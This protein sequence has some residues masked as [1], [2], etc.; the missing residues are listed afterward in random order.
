MHGSD[1]ILMSDDTTGDK[2]TGINNDLNNTTN[3]QNNLGNSSDNVHISE[4]NPNSLFSL[5][6]EKEMGKKKAEAEDVVNDDDVRKMD[7]LQ[8]INASA[9]FEFLHA[10]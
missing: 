3:N 10:C 4:F 2:G 5:Q 1:V 7:R 8:L 6:G 9:R